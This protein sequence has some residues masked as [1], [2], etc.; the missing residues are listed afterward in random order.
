MSRTVH[1][2]T[3]IETISVVATNTVGIHH[4]QG[5]WFVFEFDDEKRQVLE[6]YGPYDSFEAADDRAIQ[7]CNEIYIIASALSPDERV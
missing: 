5:Q 2:H 6:F 3:R 4:L 7:S 1:Y